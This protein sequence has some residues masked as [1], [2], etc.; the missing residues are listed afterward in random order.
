MKSEHRRAAHEVAVFSAWHP[1]V[2]GYISLVQDHVRTSARPATAWQAA[3]AAGF[4]MSVVEMNLRR[5]PWERI[6]NHNRALAL[7]DELRQAM[8]QQ[9]YAGS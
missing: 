9:R 3:E 1:W 6:R 8:R 7:A 5:T 4:D 2:L